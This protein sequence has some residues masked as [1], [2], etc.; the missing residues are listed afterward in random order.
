MLPG[1]GD[2]AGKLADW[3][4]EL[5]PARY[6]NKGSYPRCWVYQAALLLAVDCPHYASSLL[7]L[8]R[9][10]DPG[11]IE[12]LEPRLE[13]AAWLSDNGADSDKL[14]ANREFLLLRD[15]TIVTKELALR[16]Q[17][18]KRVL[19]EFM[20]IDLPANKN[21]VRAFILGL[22]VGK[23][24]PSAATMLAVYMHTE[25]PAIFLT[26][27]HAMRQIAE[28]NPIGDRAYARYLDKVLA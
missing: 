1:P 15:G 23:V 27:V 13:L 28:G 12:A 22:L 2:L 26:E 4:P 14:P 3:H 8:A 7:Q 21:M 18:W 10:D 5:D 17:N 9:R 24:Y 6:I 16:L 20:R 25:E 11:V 19:D